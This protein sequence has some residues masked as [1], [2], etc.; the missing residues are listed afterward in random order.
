MLLPESGIVK[1]PEHLDAVQAASLPC[2]A[3]TAWN[4]IIHAGQVRP[5]DVVLTQG[6]GGVSLFALQFAKLMGARVIVTSSSDQKLAVAQR[7]GADETINYV[8]NPDW[9]RRACEIAGGEGVDLV[10]EV[11]GLLNESVRAVRTSGTL[12]LIG[13]LASGQAKVDLG[14]VVTRE[15]RLQ[16]V[17]VGSRAMFE[18]MMRAIAL[19][20]LV[21]AIQLASERFDAAAAVIEALT[22]GQHFGKLV[23]RSWDT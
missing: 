2:A 15:I 10:I 22:R 5:G 7:L 8:T 16:A 9:S 11:A 23:M 19:H 13:V 21:P 3:V 12:V 18:E 17:S 14:P 4:A 6:T 20:R 1:A